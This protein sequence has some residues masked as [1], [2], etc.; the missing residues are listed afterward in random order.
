MIDNHNTIL[1]EG[2]TMKLNRLLTMVMI[3]INRKK[4]K[5]QELAELFDVSILVEKITSG[6]R[7]R[8]PKSVWSI[9]L[10]NLINRRY[11]YVCIMWFRWT[12][13][14]KCNVG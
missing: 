1:N 14:D 13:R 5:A 12:K 4:L 3:L 8:A 2:W 6:L 10:N 7:R 9:Q 11:L